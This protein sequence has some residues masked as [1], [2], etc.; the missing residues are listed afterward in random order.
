MQKNILVIGGANSLTNSIIRS[1]KKEGHRVSLLS[2]TQNHEQKYPHVFER[3]DFSYTSE[4]LL[5]VFNS[6]SPDVT[7]FVGAYDGNFRWED[8]PRD[9]VRYVS[10]VMNILTA[11]AALKKGR[12]LYISSEAVFDA[13]GTLQ[14]YTEEDEANAGNQRGA[15]LAQA[16]DI[17]R[18]FMSGS[19]T[20]IVIARLCGYY[21]LPETPEEVDDALSEY[22]VKLLRGGMANIPDDW[23]MMPISESDA[24]FFLSRI[25]LTQTHRHSC[26]HISSGNPISIAELKEMITR[27]AEL[28]GYTLPTAGAARGE[29]GPKNRL[30]AAIERRMERRA[31]SAGKSTPKQTRKLSFTH[32]RYPQA[33][34]DARRFRE[35]FGI[36][37][38]SDFNTDVKNIVS[39]MI[40]NRKGF[41][42]EDSGRHSLL[43]YLGTELGWL[44]HALVPVLENVI[45][46]VLIFLLNRAVDGSRYFARIDFYLLYVLLFA[47]L[48]GQHQAILSAFLATIGFLFTQLR[49]DSA[50]GVLLDYN[51][52]V[53]IAMLFIVG[54]AVGYLRDRLS[55]QKNEAQQDYEH[56]TQQID[57]VR[58]INES[59][60]HVKDSLQ[61]QIVNQNDSIGK[62]Y[63]ITSSLDKYESE[64]V[65]FQAMDILRQIMGSDD[66]ALYTVSGGEYAR[67]FSATTELAG[68]LGNS[69]KYKELGELYDAIKAGRPFINR[70]LMENMPMMACAISEGEEIRTIIMI[71]RLP[72]EKMTL[73]QSSML[74]VTSM[75]IQNAVL[76]ANRFLDMLQS[77]RF[78]AG[79]RILRQDA[80]SSILEAY[81]N[82]ARRHLT[83][84]T[85]LRIQTDGTE[86]GVIDMGNR[87]ASYFRQNDYL[88]IGVDGGLNVLLTNTSVR[89]AGFAL[90]RLMRGGISAEIDAAVRN[91]VRG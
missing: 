70:R 34:L 72:W 91:E 33:M 51:T 19:G 39:H 46:F 44:V 9:A 24:V 30:A 64:A 53:W 17:C 6:V 43:G 82:A 45:C 49:A 80:F 21:H 89:N 85:L 15:A 35:E 86:A 14:D 77:E 13:N 84:F 16:E 22:C 8:E 68:S 27:A 3:Y 71:W 73:G 2:G 58:E 69:I 65:L 88:G 7:V 74:T 61:T 41:L 47:I 25:A 59:N 40:E 28:A 87:A 5:D 36:N 57:D 78:I 79:T 18:R 42:R 38:L 11:Y 55:D 60:V 29:I 75:L 56:M 4:V 63:E 37:R 90:D 62:I 23:Q 1:F 54:L 20:D 10:S 52:Y 66:I 26:Y 48:Y 32:L 67:L 83:E 76:R 31:D 50:A 81:R 12:F